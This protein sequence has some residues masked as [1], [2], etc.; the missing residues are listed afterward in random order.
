MYTINS[1]SI[2]LYSSIHKITQAL[3]SYHIPFPAVL[4]ELDSDR[5]SASASMSHG[6]KIIIAFDLYG[7]LL[8]TESIAEELARHFGNDK[9]QTLATVWRR[10]QLEYTWRLNSMS[11]IE[12][13]GI[14]NMSNHRKININLL[15]M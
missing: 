14:A 10:Y 9:A 8:S 13:S 12:S 15:R 7:T 11:T 4:N 2:S 3:Y 6:K 5:K 1:Q